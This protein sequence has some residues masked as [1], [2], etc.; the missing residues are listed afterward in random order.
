VPAKTGIDAA[1]ASFWDEL[2]GTNLA[3]EIG[4]TDA[5][6]ASLERFDRAYLDLYPYLAGY[7][8]APAMA[9]RRVLEIGL[10]YGTVAELLARAGADYHGIDIAEGPVAM[11]RER[12]ARVRGALLVAPSDPD[13]PSYPVGP[14]GFA[15]MPMARLPFPT[16]LVASTDDQYV[17][18]ARARAFAEAWGSAFVDAGAGGHLNGASGLGR[19][20]DGYALLERLRATDARDA[21]AVAR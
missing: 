19:W 16:I 21:A 13:A 12:L 6:P 11:A 14:T 20:H 5:A 4:V 1:N 3:R 15:P 9:G 2:C 18:P 8:R 7:L 17:T 10:G